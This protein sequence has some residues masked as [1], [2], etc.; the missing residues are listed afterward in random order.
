M[1]KSGTKNLFAENDKYKLLSLPYVDENL[2]LNI[3]LPHEIFKLGDVKS[4]DIIEIMSKAKPT[5]LDK[6]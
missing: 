5:H 6:V 3:L 2:Q 4:K 1:D